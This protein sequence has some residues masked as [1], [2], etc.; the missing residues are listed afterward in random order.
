MYMGIVTTSYSGAFFT[1]TILK[2]LGWTSVRA[3]VMSIPIFVVATILALS[4][5]ILTDK[6]RR[7]YIFIIGGCL[8]ATIGYAILLSMS[9]VPVGA[10]YFAV[11]AIVGGGYIAHPICMV[12]LNN[13][14]G[15][16]YKRGVGSAMQIGLGNVSSFFLHCPATRP[17]HRSRAVEITE[18]RVTSPTDCGRGTHNRLLFN[19]TP[20]ED[21]D[22]MSFKIGGIIASC[23]YIP[24][25]EP[26]YHLGFGLCL[27]LVWM[28][29]ASATIFFFYIK[30]EN[31]LRDKGKRDDRYNLPEAEK[32]NL[33]DDH[34]AFR[35]T[36]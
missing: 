35:F 23:I 9:S 6:L 26:T 7:R 25:Q 17:S 33:G 8:L 2:Q 29:G 20:N 12:W 11:F 24:S 4:A 30:R 16:H 1:P 5:A 3:Q 27:A 34:P 10:R 22:H 14:L 36:L 18:I 19:V 28:C 32:R 15:G 21:A 31:K 13:N